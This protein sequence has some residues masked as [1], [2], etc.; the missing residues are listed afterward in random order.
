VKRETLERLLGDW[1]AKRPVVLVTNLASGEQRLLYPGAEAAG[2]ADA[3]LCAAAEEALLR[4]EARHLEHAGNAHFLQ[5][6]S[7]PLRMIIV[8]AVHIA[9]PLAAMAALAGYAVVIVDPRQAF[10]SQARFPGV[11]LSAE[12]PDQAVAALAPDRRTAVVTL[13]H[14]PKLDD[15]A[16]AVALRSPAFYVGS[17]GSKKTHAARLGRL[18]ALGL[19][20]SELARIHAPVGLDV[21]A[22]SPA[23]IAV[24]I[25]AEITQRLRGA[26]R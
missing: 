4:D 20:D 9:Q 14:D 25:L 24:S 18:R 15:P 19:G 2:G 21:G 8:G 17:L 23:E 1:H 13:T 10:A 6:F 7:P 5:P 12:W 16:L 26:R 22:R 3:A 11:T